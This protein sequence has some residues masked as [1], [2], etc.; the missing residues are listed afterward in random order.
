MAH[1]GRSCRRTG[2]SVPYTRT[3]RPRGRQRS[4]SG[5]NSRRG[6]VVDVVERRPV[7][8]RVTEG[9][10]ASSSPMSRLAYSRVSGSAMPGRNS[11]ACYV[12]YLLISVNQNNQNDAEK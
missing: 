11:L 9:W 12:T 6:V 10:E 1:Q 3:A 7:G 2:G 4:A 8:S 5:G